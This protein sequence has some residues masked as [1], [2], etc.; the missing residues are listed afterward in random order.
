MSKFGRQICAVRGSET[1]AYIYPINLV[2]YKMVNM[3]G[4]PNFFNKRIHEGL[5]FR[6]SFP[7][8]PERKDSLSDTCNY[9]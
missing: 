9:C 5:S 8:W 7:S 3:L 6:Q 4:G 2:S 1:H